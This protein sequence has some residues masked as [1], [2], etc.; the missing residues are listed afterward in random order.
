MLHTVIFWWAVHKCYINFLE[1]CSL[2][3]NNVYLARSVWLGKHDLARYGS[4]F[5]F[6]M[7]RLFLDDDISD[8]LQL[9]LLHFSSIPWF[10]YR[11]GFQALPGVWSQNKLSIFYWKLFCCFVQSCK[12]DKICNF[13]FPK[14]FLGFETLVLSFV[15]FLWIQ[16]DFICIHLFLCN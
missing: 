9:F 11:K 10:T 3:H 14:S 7:K 1:A 15:W 16:I 8:H 12:R 2:L 4:D 13:S 5:Q 6:A